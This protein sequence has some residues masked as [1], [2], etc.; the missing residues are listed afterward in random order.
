MPQEHF[1][2]LYGVNH[3]KKIKKL[4]FHKLLFPTTNQ[5]L[6]RLEKQRMSFGL[7]SRKYFHIV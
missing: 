2:G 7:S 6:C 1:D 5:T 3:V 4:M